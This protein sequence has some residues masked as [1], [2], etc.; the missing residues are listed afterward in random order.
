MK[1]RYGIGSRRS[2]FTIVELAAVTVAVATGGA[3]CTLALGPVG[4]SQPEG[5]EKHANPEVLKQLKDARA[6]ARQ[7]QDAT[8]VRGMMQAFVIWSQNNADKY[9]LPSE[10]DKAGATVEGEAAT[11]DT[12]ANIMSVLIYNGYISTEM[13]YSPAEASKN[14][15]I[16]KDYQF[17]M[18]KTAKKA[19]EAMWDPAFSAD[20]SNG[21]KGN[22][23]YA[24]L[25]PFGPRRERAWTS[26]F[27]T[28]EAIAGNRAPEIRSMVVD[29]A[30]KRRAALASD[31]S[32]TFLIHGE[33]DKWEGNIAYNDGHV[34][35]L[36]SLMPDDQKNADG[37]WATFDDKDGNRLLDCYF[38]DEPEDAKQN[39]LYMGIFIKSGAEKKDW[40]AIWD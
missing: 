13:A 30:G 25:Q 32:V 21:K 17:D 31:K 34:E 14:I 36:K 26:S 39:N 11:K 37:K 18:P 40:Q 24:H 4:S 8:H 9:P 38:Y 15:E 10:I 12:T 20:F 23:S 22:V 3:M 5:A 7:L 1:S 35:Y 28:T 29:A 27:I 6:K 19:A 2:G 33:E 16:D